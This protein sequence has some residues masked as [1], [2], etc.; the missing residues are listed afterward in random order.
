MRVSPVR[1][2]VTLPALWLWVSFGATNALARDPAPCGDGAQNFW[3]VFRA[4]ALK[5]QTNTLADLSAFPFEVRGTLD[6]EAPRALTRKEFLE[7]WPSLLSSD[8]GVS[9]KPTSMRAFIRTHERLAPS[10]CETGGWQFRVGNWVF[11]NRSDSW[12][13]VQAFVED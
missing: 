6:E 7:R 5:G 2:R 4:A 9:A 11:Q 8:P 1:Q 13:F 10:F 3:H 12:R